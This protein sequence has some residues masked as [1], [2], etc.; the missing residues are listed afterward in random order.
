MKKYLV[1]LGIFALLE[2]SLALYLTF[3]R[4]H[5]WQAVSTKQSMQF[6]QQLGVFT[7]VALCICL[8]SGVSGYLVSLTAIKWRQKLDNRFKELYGD[9]DGKN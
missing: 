6:L 8:V 3:W 1:L 4:E 7:G 2:I 9:E 5:F